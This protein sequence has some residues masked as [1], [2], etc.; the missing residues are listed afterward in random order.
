MKEAAQPL[1]SIAASDHPQVLLPG[2]PPLPCQLPQQR[3]P[4]AEQ[5]LSGIVKLPRQEVCEHLPAAGDSQ[6]LAQGAPG[7]CAPVQA[8]NVLQ[9]L[10]VGC[11]S[12]AGRRVQQAGHVVL[13]NLQGAATGGGELGK[14][15]G[16]AFHSHPPKRLTLCTG[17]A[18]E[19]VGVQ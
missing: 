17:Q 14:R 3:L 18:K 10:C 1:G 6:S 8:Q 2:L 5:R 16:H 7:S 4:P 12:G 13:N 15:G 9:Q 19:A 11:L